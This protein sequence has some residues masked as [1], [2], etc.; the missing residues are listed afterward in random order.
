MPRAA[1]QNKVMGWCSGQARGIEACKGANF[2][3]QVRC[4]CV[5][6]L[7]RSDGISLPTEFGSITTAGAEA[8]A[9]LHV[10]AKMS[11]SSC[12]TGS[13]TVED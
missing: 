2:S 6:A 1:V 3:S 11:L 7:S 4:I 10:A 13:D 9:R 8:V 5:A 12:T